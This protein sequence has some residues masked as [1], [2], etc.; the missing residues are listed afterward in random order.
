[1]ECQFM[2]QGIGKFINRPTKTGGRTYDKFFI[3][4]PTNVAKDSAFPFKP[5]EE[6]VIRIDGDRLVIEKT[7][8]K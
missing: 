1:M 5:G 2:I 8:R 4:I 3:Y 7:K 6:V